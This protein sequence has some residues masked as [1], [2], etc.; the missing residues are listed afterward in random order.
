M[1]DNLAIV[2]L[3][4]GSSSRLGQP[5]QLL[6]FHGES[7]LQNSVKKA[8]TISGHLYVVLGHER[9]ACEKELEG[10]ALTPIYNKE[11]HRGMGSS[12]SFGIEH[13]R[14]FDNTMIMLCD[15]PLIPTSHYRS[16]RDRHTGE[17]ITASLYDTSPA[18]PAIFP[19]R[20]Y[21][22]LLKLHA[23][24]GARSLLQAENCDVVTLPKAF[25]L[26]IDNGQDLARCL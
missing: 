4:A 26:D 16:L 14:K 6:Q 24:K 19:K 17:R 22:Q 21:A 1:A 25:S 23:D 20:F 11:Y 2:L 13:T 5:K 9:E 15:Q 7:L 18:V 12:L 8:L 3:A 10:F